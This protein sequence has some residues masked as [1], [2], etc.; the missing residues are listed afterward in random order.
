MTDLTHAF[1]KIAQAVKDTFA[2]DGTTSKQV[3]RQCLISQEISE[4]TD[5]EIILI[6]K[7][8]KHGFQN[9]KHTLDSQ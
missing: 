2:T 3:T 4:D 6:Y 9:S 5:V 7:V 1:S 8:I